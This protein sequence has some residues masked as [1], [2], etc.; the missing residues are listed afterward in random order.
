M[1]VATPEG[2][3][4]NPALV[5]EFYNQRRRQLLEVTPNKAH[6]NLKKLETTFDVTIITQNVDDL[7]ERAGSSKILHL[8]GE[9]TKVRSTQDE[10]LVYPWKKDLF[11]GDRNEEKNV[12]QI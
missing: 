7:H 6:F 2:F 5:L 3:Q 10:T 11:L 8:H 1:E 4:R 12:V 9:L